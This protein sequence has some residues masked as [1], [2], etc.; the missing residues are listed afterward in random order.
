MLAGNKN[1]NNSK[2]DDEIDNYDGINNRVA[3]RRRMDRRRTTRFNDALGRR[4][5]VERR[6]SE[7]VSVSV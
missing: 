5:G 7:S 6:L 3:I 1:N 4:S 2:S